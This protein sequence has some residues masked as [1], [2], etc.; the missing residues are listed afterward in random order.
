M[1]VRYVVISFRQYVFS[2]GMQ[3]SRL[4][5][6]VIPDVCCGVLDDRTKLWCTKYC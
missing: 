6:S 5:G 3:S 1:D 4:H 2:I